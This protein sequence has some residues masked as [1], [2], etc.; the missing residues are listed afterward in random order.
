MTHTLML[1]PV[2]EDVGLSMVSCGVV[3]AIQA[4]KIEVNY[5]KPI[6]GH[7]HDKE[8]MLEAIKTFFDLTPPAPLLLREI[9]TLLGQGRYSEIL[10]KIAHHFCAAG[11]AEPE[12]GPQ[13]VTVIQGLDFNSQNAPY[14]A[15]LNQLV[16]QAFSAKVIFVVSQAS[17]PGELLTETIDALACFYRDRMRAEVLGYIIC[18]TDGAD[19]SELDRCRE[20]C[21]GTMPVC[22]ELSGEISS[23]RAQVTRHIKT[24][25]ISRLLKSSPCTFLTPPFFLHKL[26]DSARKL[27]KRIV[28][29]EGNEIRTLKAA[30]ICHERQIARCVLLGNKTEIEQICVNSQI[31]LP[32]NIEIIYPSDIADKYVEHMFELRQHKGLTKKAARELLHNNEIVLGTMMLEQGDVDGLVSGAIHLTSDTVRPALQLIKTSKGQRIISSSFFMCLPRETVLYADCAL[33][34]NPSVEDLADIAIQSADTA[35]LFGMDPRVGFLSFSTDHSGSGEDVDN[36]IKAV[37]LAKKKQPDLKIEGPLQYDAA[38]DLI[39]AKLK[40]PDSK[41]AG[42]IN[43]Y[44]FPNL[45]TGNIVYKAVQRTNNIVC[46]GPVLQGIKKPVN[47]LSRGASAED[48]VYTIAV[49]AIQAGKKS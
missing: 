17:N 36:I 10:E 2:N 4:Q 9:L 14:A 23:L 46:V 49:T 43:V 25:W 48:I 3:D 18:G 15:L 24:D 12:K 7:V 1:V 33:N 21:L 13:S 40:A 16:V 37:Q 34:R 20:K 30:S 44:I 8:E 47:D 5:F 45:N 32:D 41:I 35:K 19:Q 26:V 11:L 29:P 22:V 39:V 27:N 42:K 38:S 6:A 28:L 31:R